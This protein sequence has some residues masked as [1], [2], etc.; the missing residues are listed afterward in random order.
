MIKRLAILLVGAILGTALFASAAPTAQNFTNIQPFT[1]NTYYNGTGVL[2]WSSFHA[3]NASTTQL[4]SDIICLTADAC[5][6]TWPLSFSTTSADFWQTQRNFFSTSSTDYY[7]SVNN[8]FSTSSVNYWKSVTD[9]FSTT[10]ANYLLNTYDKGFFFSTTSAT[11]F[12]SVSSLFS[13]TSTDFWKTQRNFFA[14]TSADFYVDSS[15]T[16]PKTYTNNTFLGTQTFNSA[17]TTNLVVSS[18][19]GPSGCATFSPN[20]TISNVG[21]PCAASGA[22]AYP[23]TPSTNVV[24][25]NTVNTSAT[26]T[27]IDDTQGFF[28][29][30][31]SSF[32]PDI[33]LDGW[34]LS[35]TTTVICPEGQPYGCKY[36]G[37][38]G[39]VQAVNVDGVTNIHLKQ[40]AYTITGPLY[41]ATNG[42]TMIGEGDKSVI[43]YNGTGIKVAIMSGNLGTELNGMYF[44]NFRVNETGA[45]GRSTC[46]DISRIT[47]TKIEHVHCDKHKVGFM[48]ST[49]QSYYNHYDSDDVT[50]LTST[51]GTSDSFGFYLGDNGSLD[52]GPIDNFVTNAHVS[53]FIGGSSTAY[54]F[55]SHTITCISC[56]S[57]GAYIGMNV[58]PYGS[59]LNAIMY[60]EANVENVLLQASQAEVGSY[61]LSGE[62]A[63]A[64]RG[65]AYNIVDQGAAGLCVNA[66]VQYAA[67]NYC[68]NVKQGFGTT[69][70][71]ATLHVSDDVEANTPGLHDDSIGLFGAR[72]PAIEI[73]HGNGERYIVNGSFNNNNTGSLDFVLSTSSLADNEPSGVRFDMGNAFGTGD[74]LIQPEVQATGYGVFEP[75]SSSSISGSTGGTV[76]S[77]R[78]S[79]ILL[80]PNRNANVFRIT[81]PD[82]YTGFSTT[83]PGGLVAIAGRSGH[84]ESLL[85]VST[86]TSAFS[87]STAVRIGNN[88]NM[89]FTNGAGVSIG[90]GVAP[91]S[92]GLIAL[93]SVG[94]GTTSPESKLEVD[95]FA[96]SQGLLGSLGTG[97]S[98]YNGTAGTR[99]VG[100]SNLLDFVVSSSTES[101]VRF[102]RAN[103]FGK[104][105]VAIQP[106]VQNNGYA[107]FEGY[108][109]TSVTGGTAISSHGAGSPVI[110]APNRAP[111]LYALTTGAVTV[112]TSTN[113]D[114][115]TGA[116]RGTLLVQEASDDATHG[117]TVLNLEGKN[118]GRFWEDA[119]TVESTGATH[120]D[121]GSSGQGPLI[122]NGYSAGFV[123][124]GTTSPTARLAISTI[125]GSAAHLLIISTSSPTATTTAL[126][127]DSLGNFNFQNG[128]GIAMGTGVTPPINGIITTGNV[129]IGT[130]TPGSALSIQGNVFLAG[131]ITS[132]STTASIFPN[133]SSTAFSATT[134]CLTGDTCRTTWP[135]ASVSGGAAGMLTS[136]TDATTLTSTS[137]PTAARF[138]ATSTAASQFPYASSTMLSTNLLT[139]NLG[140]N[141]IAQLNDSSSAS[142]FWGLSIGF[143]S[144]SGLAQITTNGQALTFNTVGT[145]NTMT[146]G[147]EVGRFTVGGAF[148]VGTTTFRM[149]QMTVSSTTASQ[150]SLLSGSNTSAWSFRNLADGGLYLA[151]STLSGATTSIPAFRIDTNGVLYDGNILNCNG[152]TSALGITNN[153]IQ[154]DTGVSDARLK[155][156]IIPI[157]T[158]L[159]TILKLKPV[160]FFWKDTTNHNTA[161]TLMQY[162]FTAQS[163]QPILPSAVDKSPDGYLTLDKTALI[164]PMVSALQQLTHEMQL[165]LARL[166]GD[167]ARLNKMQLEIDAINAKLK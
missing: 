29:E 88:G 74:V 50:H 1:D 157:T 53:N 5:I 151:T 163:V 49:S 71:H 64:V 9:L 132:T 94:I 145:R 7:K 91:P 84:T 165:I 124:I 113:I 67:S 135:S 152:A 20:G 70:P 45:G 130:T 114:P 32:S 104:N 48:A 111:T 137:T 23:F 11:Y 82:G 105:D 10:S 66:R 57:E 37:G 161:S 3:V 123:G 83:S 98:L 108:S 107:V 125:G 43:Q 142:G 89:F 141:Q 69:L 119:G 73:S 129:G 127:V 81:Y 85:L 24:N 154:C 158:G 63:A 62:I 59:G 87:T 17:S 147:T 134:I 164:A 4:A 18:A 167:E 72:G 110:L 19:G 99:I 117:I 14:T 121:S 51:N 103:I 140:T 25:G 12:L 58:G 150:L 120:L 79:D 153:A 144:Q 162:G 78:A 65:N 52:G 22:A 148:D 39:L 6:T 76:I 138:Y 90:N 61:N 28:A 96:G 156:D 56:D 33:L 8:F 112:G 159:D 93:G 55:N 133:A 68:T 149:G 97:I 100:E 30:A 143:L 95:G 27:A 41:P 44:G 136:W 77:S 115:V 122:L 15:T 42:F 160:T 86:S 126:D 166:D 2:R 92:S 75:Y 109:T 54:Y 36:Y 60:L 47:E 118:S 21:S 40:G 26:S 34:P 101:G 116:G 102:V 128:A 131:N 38:A 35:T 16:I 80:A 155:K 106:E 139:V 31:T 146:P 13:T 46:M